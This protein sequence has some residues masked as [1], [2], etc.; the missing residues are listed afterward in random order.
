MITEGHSKGRQHK[1]TLLLD[2]LEE[3]EKPEVWTKK[4]SYFYIYM[5]IHLNLSLS[6]SLSLS[7][8]IYIYTY[9]Y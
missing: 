2:M 8:Y 5:S 1:E 7:W 6:L 4:S 9:Y 3:D